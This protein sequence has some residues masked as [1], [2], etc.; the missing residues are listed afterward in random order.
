MAELGGR[1]VRQSAV[2]ALLTPGRIG[3]QGQEPSLRLSEQP[4]RAIWQIAAWHAGD[5]APLRAALAAQLSLVLPEGQ[6]AAGSDR[7]ALTF[8]VAPRRWWLVVPEASRSRFDATL[9]S[10]L[11][12]RAARTELSHARSVL[13]LGGPASRSV[14]AKLCRIDLH[15]RA[16]PPGR[17]AQTPLGQIA[18]LIH[19]I[20]EL[21]SFDLYLPRSFAESATASLID[22]AAEFG[23]EVSERN[24]GSPATSG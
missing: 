17:V 12:T 22:A 23:V 18:A 24:L 6:D 4:P 21:P 16:F 11:G 20:D 10:A 2:G 9:V 7:G 3:S 15:P 19:A 13:H 8:Q 5:V 1:A 14:L